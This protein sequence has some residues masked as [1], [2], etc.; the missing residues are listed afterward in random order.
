MDQTTDAVRQLMAEMN[1]WKNIELKVRATNKFTHVPP[2]LAKTPLFDHSDYTYIETA[3]GDRFLEE[4]HALPDGSEGRS[5]SYYHGDRGAK[6]VYDRKDSS[7]QKQ[8]SITRAFDREDKPGSTGRPAPLKF[9]YVDKVPLYEAL[10]KAEHL[11][12]APGEFGVCDRY[13]FRNVPVGSRQQNQEYCL[14]RATGLPVRVD[15]FGQSGE[16]EPQA[17]WSWAATK[18]E[19]IQ[20]HPFAT[21]SETTYY[22]T[23]KNS[24]DVRM[25]TSYDVTSVRFNVDLS[26]VAFWPTLGPGVHVDDL[27]TMTVTTTPGKSK[28]DPIQAATSSTTTPIVVEPPRDWS[29][30]LSYGGIAL[31]A[32]VLVA[33]VIVWRRRG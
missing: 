6:V 4:V 17:L 7:V 30:V 32:A 16:G 29:S 24:K 11:G 13:L 2:S 14:D 9:F 23:D 26:A 28:V 31:G 18:V 27:T 10:P 25:T 5:A 3:S 19:T 33:A 20:K 8:V 1:S 15:S 22:R 21:R 12:E